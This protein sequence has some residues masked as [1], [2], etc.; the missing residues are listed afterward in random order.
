VHEHPVRATALESAL[1]VDVD[2]VMALGLAKLPGERYQRAH[3]SIRDLD[4]A[5][6]GE[7][8]PETRVRGDELLATAFTE[9]QTAV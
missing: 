4:R 8:D 6:R 7:L 9:T 3:D 5:L 2:R 1:H